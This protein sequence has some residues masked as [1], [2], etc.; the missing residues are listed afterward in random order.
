MKKRQCKIKNGKLYCKVGG[1]WKQISRENINLQS[2]RPFEVS[3]SLRKVRT[4][5]C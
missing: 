4:N 3:S 1:K 2:T 5:V